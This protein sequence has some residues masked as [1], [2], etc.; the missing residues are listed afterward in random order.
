MFPFIC[1]SFK[2]LHQCL[3]FSEYIK[4]Y[5]S[6]IKFIPR[7]FILFDVTLKQDYFLAFP[8]LYFIQFSSV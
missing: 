4:F 5:T 2:F 8:F 1:T 3:N 7:Y 6:L